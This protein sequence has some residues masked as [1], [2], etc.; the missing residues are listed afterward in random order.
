MK[1]TVRLRR[2]CYV[3]FDSYKRPFLYH[4]RVRSSRLTVISAIAS[5]TLCI[6]YAV[7]TPLFLYGITE[8]LLLDNQNTDLAAEKQA[9]RF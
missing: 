6:G 3:L 7:A 8:P 1:Q 4:L 2:G 9:G 5:F